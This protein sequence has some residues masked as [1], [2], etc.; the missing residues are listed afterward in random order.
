MAKILAL[1]FVG[2]VIVGVVTT[3]TQWSTSADFR[4]I[5]G[6][7]VNTLDPARMSYSHDIR[8]VLALW[9]G[10]TRLDVE[11][12]RPIAGA[13][14][15][16]TISDDHRTYT[17]TIR[18]DARWSNGDAVT[19]R[20]FVRGWRRAIEPGTSDVY[21]ELIVQYL[22]GATDYVA[23]R[24][25]FTSLLGLVRQLQRGS[26]I[27]VTAAR[28]ALISPVGQQ[29]A[30]QNQFEIPASDV[31][32]SDPVWSQLVDQL[33]K[34][35]VDWRQQG[36]ALLDAHLVEM[37][38]RWSQVG[39]RAVDNQHLEVRLVHPTAYFLDLTAFSTYLP[40][41]ESIEMLRDH[42]EGR[43]LTDVGL[44]SYDDQWTKPDYRRNGYPGVVTNGPYRLTG[45][46]FKQRLLL[47][48]NAF[49]WN[50]T[51]VN[52][53]HV[54]VVDV[55]YQNTA[56]MLYDQGRTDL[57]CDLATDFTPDLVNQ[58]KTGQR[59]DIHA[60]PAFGT[61][62]YNF[63]CRPTL[64][65]GRPNPLSNVAVRRAL[66]MAVNKQEI[67]DH[68]A[69]LG[70]PVANTLV[71]A[72]RIPNYPSP[73]GLPYDPQ[74]AREEL[75]AAGYPGGK[76]LPTIE[77]LY[78]T[79]FRHELF[80]QAIAHMWHDE[81]GISCRLVGKE[82]KTFAED[83]ANGRFMVGRSSWFGD[84]VDPSTFLNLFRTG[85]GNNHSGFSDPKYDGLLQQAAVERDP[86]Q[87]FRLLSQAEQYIVE[88]Q[89]PMLP[90]Y[91]YVNVSAWRSYVTD[92]YSD[93]Q[94]HLPLEYIKVERK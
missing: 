61:Y 43:P 34:R 77:I 67:V 12:V 63:N 4:F 42:Y 56:W 29:F 18:P 37:E 39:V 57:I 59:N 53:K 26:P 25:E 72:G 45:W 82:V 79:G 28:T 9:E 81:L 85:D 15:L 5:N 1:I 76:G 14:F 74:K 48:A 36:D 46:N 41:H 87:R 93:P 19:A 60:T 78:N 16:P 24:T 22:D 32:A 64:W 44:W 86:E 13:A 31:P 89:L 50:A 65:D 52:L 88:E 92:V 10:L 94:L 51:A 27:S 66:A 55:E 62:F 7:S 35:R 47:E 33:R 58:Q 68:V 80:A 2:I 70:N 6:Q 49:Y 30:A 71:P 90:I 8:I 84:Y 73:A 21:A 40:I 83:H 38:Q 75:A 54:E 69:R 23:W 91:T 3:T 11:T 20:D 17:F